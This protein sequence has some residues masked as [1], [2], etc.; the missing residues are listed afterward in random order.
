[1]DPDGVEV[2]AKRE[3]GTKK[4]GGETVLKDF[5]SSG[6]LAPLL[7]RLEIRRIVDALVEFLFLGFR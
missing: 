2:D 4:I 7:F 3:T 6:K 5:R 1:V